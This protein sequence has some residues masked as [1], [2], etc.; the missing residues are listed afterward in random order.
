MIKTAHNILSHP[1][2]RDYVQGLQQVRVRVRVGEWPEKGSTVRYEGIT[3]LQGDVEN[4]SEILQCVSVQGG[5]IRRQGFEIQSEV[6]SQ[7]LEAQEE[8]VQELKP[9]SKNVTG[10]TQSQE[11]IQGAQEQLQY[12]GPREAKHMILGVQ[13]GRGKGYYF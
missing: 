1:D 13:Q 3:G 9:E 8:S 6:A 10:E 7:K 12:S 5:K 2:D 11:E 4:K